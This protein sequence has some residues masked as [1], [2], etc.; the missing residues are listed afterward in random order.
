MNWLADNDVSKIKIVS[1]MPVID[2]F[3][4]LNK[5]IAEEEKKISKPSKAHSKGM[6]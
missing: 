6:R 1:E 2:F 3:I 4:M 5:K